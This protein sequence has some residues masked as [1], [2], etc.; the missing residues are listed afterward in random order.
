LDSIKSISVAQNT[1]NNDTEQPVAKF[2]PKLYK[3]RDQS[4]LA[5]TGLRK[6][7]LTK[8]PLQKPQH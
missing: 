1:A 3:L 4:P 5:S 2:F 7:R 8:S 6:K